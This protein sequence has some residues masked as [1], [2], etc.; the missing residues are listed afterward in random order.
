MYARAGALKELLSVTG[1]PMF[2]A[3]STSS[4]SGMMPIPVKWTAGNCV[5]TCHRLNFAFGEPLTV[6]SFRCYGKP[7]TEQMC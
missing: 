2:E 1:D 3:R 7:L 6:F 4:L 5:T